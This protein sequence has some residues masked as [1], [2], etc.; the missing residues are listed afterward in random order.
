[1]HKGKNAI[2]ENRIGQG[3][4][5]ML[6]CDPGYEIMK[7][8]YLKYAGEAGIVPMATGDK[9]VLVVN[10]TDGK[11]TYQVIINLGHEESTIE[12]AR[13]LVKDLLTGDPITE[14]KLVLAPFRVIIAA[15]TEESQHRQ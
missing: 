13:S 10:R 2:V 7:T 12:P 5:V 1:M 4:V 8:L 11:K 9:N 3:K 6:G 14:G 15:V